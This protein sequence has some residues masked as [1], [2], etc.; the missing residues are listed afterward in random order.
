[1]AM[2]LAN[3]LQMMVLICLGEDRMRHL[4]LNAF[5]RHGIR[6][7]CSGGTRS[8]KGRRLVGSNDHT[9]DANEKGTGCSIPVLCVCGKRRQWT[10]S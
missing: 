7:H 6:S 4:C 1:M 3:S 2:R 8:T 10:R 9:D 5:C